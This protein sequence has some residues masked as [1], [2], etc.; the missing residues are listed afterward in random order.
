MNVST[1]NL[2]KGA[3]LL[4]C[5]VLLP[6]VFHYFNLGGQIFLPMHVP[7]LVAGFVLPW[8]YGALTG[9]LAPV[10][11]FLITSMPQMPGGVIMMCELA[12]Y[13]MTASILY[14]KLNVNIYISLIVSMVSGRLVSIIGNWVLATLFLGRTFNLLMF[15]NALF[16][17]A[18]P[19]IIIQLIFVPVI[20]RLVDRGRNGVKW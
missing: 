6:V 11:S 18:L 1:N 3:L 13:G 7:I 10:L 14:R 9:F 12:T 15:S 4:S 2:V 19:G 17:I 5:A 8:K 16:I 20:V